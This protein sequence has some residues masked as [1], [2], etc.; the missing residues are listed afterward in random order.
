MSNRT[1][2]HRAYLIGAAFAT[3][4]TI[5][6]APAGAVST[7]LYDFIVTKEGAPFFLDSFTDGLVPPAAPNFASGNS[8]S[9]Y[10]GGSYPVGSETGGHLAVN[11]A[12]GS[13]GSSADNVPSQTQRA[14]L[15]GNADPNNTINGLKPNHTFTVSALVDIE[16]ASGS[17][18]VGV[19]FSDRLVNPNNT[20]SL[21][22]FVSVDLVPSTN[23]VRLRRQDFVADKVFNISSIAVPAGADQVRLIL[24]HPAAGISAVTGSAEF[25]DAGESMGVYAIGGLA[26]I[27]TYNN[28]VRPEF[29]AGVSLPVPEPERHAMMLVG[30]GLIG[31]QL[32]RKSR[33]S[34]ARR[35]C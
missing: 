7:V 6:S 9:Y 22:E 12:F 24:S 31:W 15:L 19:R 32:R 28:F 35:F 1:A 13:A 33:R 23:S 17:G 20:S 18:S 14:T 27:F 16:L 4:S 30:L 3:L 26:T 2:Q 10:V 8:T 34:S 29:A 25:F 5:A 21:R 11:S